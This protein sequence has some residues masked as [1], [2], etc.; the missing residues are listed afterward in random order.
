ME[1]R[2]ACLLIFFS[3]RTSDSLCFLLSPLCSI[4]RAPLP[5]VNPSLFAEHLPFKVLLPHIPGMLLRLFS[6][7]STLMS[8]GKLSIFVL[9][10]PL[11]SSVFRSSS[12]PQPGPL[13]SANCTYSLQGLEEC[14]T[15]LTAF[16]A[17]FPNYRDLIFN[18]S[19]SSGYAEDIGFTWF[20]LCFLF[21]FILLGG[22]VECF[23]FMQ[24]LL[25]QLLRTPQ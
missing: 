6:V 7:A 19:L 17:S 14:G 9:R 8:T 15:Q 12:D 21:L 23:R 5:S 11:S 16:G 3:C 20:C 4:H 1:G 22:Y 18:P 2:S 24:S 25:P 13:Y 10:L